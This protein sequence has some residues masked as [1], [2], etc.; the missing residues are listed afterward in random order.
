MLVV[1]VLAVHGLCRQCQQTEKSGA[2][3]GDES[4]YKKRV[5]ERQRK[6]NVV[7]IQVVYCKISYGEEY[8]G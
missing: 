2:M 3:L 6:G 8:R 5:H 1:V 4:D 7:L